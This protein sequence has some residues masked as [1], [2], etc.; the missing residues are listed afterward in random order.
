MANI[1][2]VFNNKG[3]VGKSTICWN[4]A[5]SLGHA[6]KSVLLIDFD[7]QCN[8]SLAVLGEKRFVDVLPTQ[9]VPYGETIRSYLQRFLQNTGGEEVFLHQGEHTDKHVYLVAGDFWLNVYAESLSVGSDLLTG[10][11]FEPLRRS[12]QAD[13]K[14]RRDFQQKIRLCYSG[15]SALLRCA[16]A[17]RILFFR[18]LYRSVH[19]RQLQ[20]LLRRINWSN[21]S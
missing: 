12:Q 18:L 8:L 3:G 21:G 13:Y 16:R 9:N 4:V 11:G 1:I 17:C 10:T 19:F 6:G 14:G 5:N 2:S 7:P 15:P 20:R